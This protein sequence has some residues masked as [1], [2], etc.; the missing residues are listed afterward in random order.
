MKVDDL[1]GNILLIRLLEGIKTQSRGPA[2][3]ARKRDVGSPV[4]GDHSAQSVTA[5][6]R[7]QQQRQVEQ[8]LLS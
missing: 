2:G 4:K 8:L 3:Q 6:A 7:Q 5:F 1:P